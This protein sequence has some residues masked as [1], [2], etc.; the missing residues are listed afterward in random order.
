MIFLNSDKDLLLMNILLEDRNGKKKILFAFLVFNSFQNIEF[1]I[2]I[3]H[4]SEGYDLHNL[5]S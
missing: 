3:Y 2:K 4:L 1:N 5:N